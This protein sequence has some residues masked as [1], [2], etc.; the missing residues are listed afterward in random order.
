MRRKISHSDVIL[1]FLIF[2]GFGVLWKMDSDRIRNNSINFMFNF[3]FNNLAK[4]INTVFFAEKCIFCRK[5][6]NNWKINM[7]KY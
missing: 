6:V 7:R 5:M 3:M 2:T 4:T 1:A